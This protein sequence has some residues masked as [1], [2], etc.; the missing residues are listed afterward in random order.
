MRIGWIMPAIVLLAVGCAADGGAGSGTAT[1][2]TLTPERALEAVRA[3]MTAL[4]AAINAG[5]AA[6]IERLLPEGKD[7]EAFMA[8]YFGFPA[9]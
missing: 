2:Q 6:S 1:E 3:N 7:A 8:A 9:G 5:D 4:A